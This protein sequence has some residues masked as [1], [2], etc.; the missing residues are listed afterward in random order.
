VAYPAYEKGPAIEYIFIFISLLSSCPGGRN[1]EYRHVAKV[2]DVVPH[3][4]TMLSLQELTKD[5]IKVDLKDFCSAW[6]W[7]LTDQKAVALISCVGDMFLIGKDDTINWLDTSAGELKKIADNIQ[8]FEEQLDNEANIDNWFLATLVEK[9]IKSGKTLKENEVY[10]FRQM[11]VLGGDYSI[12]NLQPTDI[13]VHFALTGQIAEQIKDLPD[14]T[15]INIK[16]K[17]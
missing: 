3:F 14:G 13:S 17:H 6:Q 15:K 16:I 10:S 2:P 1:T 11:P 8:Q 5:T 4:I 7:C 12:E 9:L